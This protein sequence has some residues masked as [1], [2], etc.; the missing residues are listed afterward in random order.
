MPNCFTIHSRR[1][2]P[3]CIGPPGALEQFYMHSSR[4]FLPSMR[5]LQAP[6]TFLPRRRLSHTSVNA[7]VDTPAITQR[8]TISLHLPGRPPFGITPNLFTTTPRI[9]PTGLVVPFIS[10]DIPGMF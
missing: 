8:S 3:E 5:M 10:P 1:P 2:Q 4:L 9:V 7:I 6:P